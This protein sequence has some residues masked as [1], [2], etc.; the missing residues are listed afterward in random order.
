M[1]L[2]FADLQIFKYNTDFLNS[3]WNTGFALFY[4][5]GK[6]PVVYFPLFQAGTMLSLPILWGL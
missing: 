1:I 3:N 6:F 4:D 2:F 5:E